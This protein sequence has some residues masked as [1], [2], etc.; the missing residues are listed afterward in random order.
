LFAQYD[1]APP[2]WGKLFL[3]RTKTKPGSGGVDLV[4]KKT[5]L[6]KNKVRLGG[7]MLDRD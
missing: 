4:S 1:A 7:L 5:R 3:N 2:A 6:K